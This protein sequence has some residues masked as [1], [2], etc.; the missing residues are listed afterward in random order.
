MAAHINGV[1][2]LDKIDSHSTLG[3]EGVSNSL[4]YRVHEIE[5]H[6]HSGGR[7][8]EAAAV[9]AGETHVAD[10]VGD[11]AGAFQ[12]DAGNDTWGE[13]VQIL[14]SSDTP[15]DSGKVY[16]D[17]HVMIV[18]DT[19]RAATYFLQLARGD[20]G[21]A[22]LAAGTYSD[23]PPYIATVQKETGAV[24]VQTGRAPAGSKV[25]ARCKCPGQNTGTLDFYFGLHEYEG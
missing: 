11:G 3:L 12:I 5:R 9:P 22:G 6:L 23:L 13:W 21:A 8:F 16:F 1:R 18:E 20:S 4:A 2:D 24:I 14:G 17:P 25:W 15:V 7:W 19:E 10:S